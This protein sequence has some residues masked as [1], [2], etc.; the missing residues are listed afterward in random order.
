MFS[1]VESLQNIINFFKDKLTLIDFF[2]IGLGTFLIFYQLWKR[3]TTNSNR[4]CQKA[5]QDSLYLIRVEVTLNYLAT[6]IEFL[7]LLGLLG[8][9]WGLMNGLAIIATKEMP[10]IKDLAIY[11][12][13][14]ISTTFWGLLFALFN[15]FLF[16]FLQAYFAELIAY[17][18]QVL[19]QADS[20]QNQ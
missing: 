1:E 16:N 4:F 14:A 19:P 8:T 11:I 9:V 20:Q 12:A 7:P 10:T 15:L 17:C 2:I 13:P 18:R 3:F 5:R 6:M